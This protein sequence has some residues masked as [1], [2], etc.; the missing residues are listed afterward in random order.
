MIEAASDARQ[1]NGNDYKDVSEAIKHRYRVSGAKDELH[2]HKELTE[3]GK[4]LEAE[5]GCLFREVLVSVAEVILPDSGT[6]TTVNNRVFDLTGGGH[7]YGLKEVIIDVVVEGLA[8]RG[9]EVENHTDFAR[10]WN[11]ED[12]ITP[13]TGDRRG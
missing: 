8:V 12:G 3:P 5:V 11:C 10:L 7:D 6:D 13:E 4:T 2:L 9:A 1:G